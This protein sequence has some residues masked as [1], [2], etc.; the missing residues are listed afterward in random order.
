M[1]NSLILFALL[2]FSCILEARELSRKPT[3]EFDCAV[4]IQKACDEMMQ[5]ADGV[6]ELQMSA[7]AELK[8]DNKRLEEDLAK[9][10]TRIS[11]LENPPWSSDPMY[12]GLTGV[13]IGVFLV[14][15]LQK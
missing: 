5:A 2:L 7:Y 8:S 15:S 1:F 6:I 14:L 12:T 4:E 10:S 11:E 13:L 3:T 9:S